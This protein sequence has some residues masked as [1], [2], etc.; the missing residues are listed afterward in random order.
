MARLTLASIVA[1]LSRPASDAPASPVTGAL[2]SFTTAKGSTYVVHPDGTTTR[3]KAARPEHPGDAGPQPQSE[4]TVYLDDAGLQALSEIQASGASGRRQ[5]ARLPDGRMGVRYLD[6]PSAG[7]FERRTVTMV[8][9][10]PGVGLFPL[11]IWD[12]GRGHHFGTRITAVTPTVPGRGS[13]PMASTPSPR[14]SRSTR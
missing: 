12:E 4:G 14:P 3:H 7:R 9:S 6:G 1:R 13:A 2:V 5:L 11:E 8:A 10:V